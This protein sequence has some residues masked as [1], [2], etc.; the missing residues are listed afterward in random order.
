[1]IFKLALDANNKR[2]SQIFMNL[3]KKGYVIKNYW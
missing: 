3:T 2:A 1:M